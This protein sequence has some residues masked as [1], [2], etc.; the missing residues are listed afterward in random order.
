MPGKPG[1]IPIHGERMQPFNISVPPHILDWVKE[2][3]GTQFVRDILMDRY[4]EDHPTPWHHKHHRHH[5]HG[6]DVSG[7]PGVGQFSEE[8]C[9]VSGQ[10]AVGQFAVMGPACA[11]LGQFPV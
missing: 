6:G 8:V 7:S 2:M 10:A 4:K 1:P 3:G 11:E 5:R 9:D